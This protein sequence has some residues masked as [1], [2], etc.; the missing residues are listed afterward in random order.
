MTAFDVKAVIFDMDGLLMDSEWLGVEAIHVCAKRQGFH[1]PEAACK[2]CIGVNTK[3]SSA[4][5]QAQCP[6]LD[7]DRLFRD[8]STYMHEKAEKGLIPVKKG[9]WQLM[10]YLQQRHIPCAVASSSRME[11]ICLYLDG[12]GLTKYFQVLLS[13]SGMPSKPAPDVFLL[14]AEKMGVQPENCL[15]LEDSYNGV[16]AGRAAGMQVCMVPD[17]LP[18]VD[19]VAPYVDHVLPDLTKVLELMEA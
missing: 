3:A 12:V 8:F 14:A 5:L 11:T 6:G 1:V 2:A 19:E 7:T 10:E 18:Y 13:G 9:V 15:V 16:K 4:L 17:V